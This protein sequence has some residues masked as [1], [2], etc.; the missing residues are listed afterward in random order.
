MIDNPT[1]PA[2]YHHHCHLTYELLNQ[3][4]V[5]KA[6]KSVGEEY[7]FT[8]ELFNALQQ[9]NSL[10]SSSLFFCSLAEVEG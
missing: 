5:F 10:L 6:T 8:Q 1:F 3:P 9:I 2:N 7:G 4:L